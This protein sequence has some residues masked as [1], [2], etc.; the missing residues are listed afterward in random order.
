MREASHFPWGASPGMS[1][2]AAIEVR[3]PRTGQIDYRFTPPDETQL[4]ALAE[5]LRAHQGAWAA[6]ALGERMEAL[7]AFAAALRE[8]REAIVDALVVDTGRQRIASLE[9]EAVLSGIERWCTQAP[10]LITQH[11][12]RSAALPSVEYSSELVPYPLCVVI[13]PWNFPFLLSMIDTVPALLAGCAVLVKPSEVA[14]RF[15]EAV[16]EALGRVPQL[17]AVLG[18]VQGAG[19]TGAALIRLADIVC[20]TGSVRTGR[21]VAVAAAERFVPAFLELGGKDP[22]I[23]LPGSD[24]DAASEAALRASVQATGQACQSIER[25]YVARADFPAFIE[26]LLAKAQAQD[27]NWPD[28]RQG[29]I[30]PLIFDR[31]AAVIAEQLDEARARGARILCGGDIERHGGGVWIRPTVVV[32]VDHTMRLMREETFG[33]II[34]VMTYDSVDAA[35]RLANDSEYGLSAA[36]FGPDREQAMAVARALD[37]GAISINDA[38]LTSFVHEAEKQSFKDSGIGGSRMGPAGLMRFLRRKAYLVQGGAP[39]PMAMLRE[40]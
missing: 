25:V 20:F 15:V 33:P 30:G 12:G 37:A 24:L 19:D 29:S 35:I 3:N 4:K 21:K 7:R 1:F 17:R 32:D 40:G 26:K 6:L 23:V 28:I 10:G 13:S 9:F 8:A 27:L 34:P 39:L 38:G 36:V 2:L 16:R 22:L 14:P 31:Q 5:N 18:F 11:S